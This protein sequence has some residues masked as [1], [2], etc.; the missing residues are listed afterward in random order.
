MK[1]LFA[2][3]AGRSAAIVAVLLITSMALFVWWDNRAAAGEDL[4]RQAALVAAVVA[5]TTDEDALRTALT[6][7]SPSGRLA[8]HLADGRRVGVSRAAEA[9]VGEAARRTMPLT[10]DVEDGRA[11]LRP[12][13]APDGSTAVVEVYQPDGGADRR[14]LAAVGAF[15]LIGLVAAGLAI[16]TAARSTTPV[17]NQMRELG[18]AATTDLADLTDL[19]KPAYRPPEK[20]VPELAAIAAM[21]NRVGVL[22]THLADREHKM[23]ADVSHRL[24][25]PLTA[26]RLDA[27][28]VG[29]G[30]VADRIR[31]AVV[32]LEHDI[33]DIIRTA[34]RPPE[35]IEPSATMCDLSAVVLSRMQFWQVLAANQRRRCEVDC[36]DGPAMVPLAEDEVTD[37]VNNL[38]GNVFRHTEPGTPLAVT[39]GRHAGWISLVVDDGGPGIADSEAALRRGVSGGGSTGLG[40]DIVRAKVEATG[41]AIHIERGKLGGARIRLRLTEAGISHDGR[42]PRAWRLWR[43]QH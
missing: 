4:E 43:G 15:S 33:G 21:I 42:P 39:V 19:T 17:V 11:F 7:S 12:A 5:V 3:V 1:A 29:T 36:P 8:V 2:R 34:S 10:V 37:I 9:D 18:A 27:E 35:P 6:R 13:T 20:T 30:P 41:G 22:A 38:V 31:S 16:V 28:A 26:L 32:T 23:I 24:R 25:T 40:L 14:T